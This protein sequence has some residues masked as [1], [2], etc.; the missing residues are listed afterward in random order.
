MR[1]YFTIAIFLVLINGFA[2]IP[3]NGLV[4]YWPFSGNAN[5]ISGKGNN[6]IV[7]G[8]ILTTDRFGNANS[9]YH[10][11]GSNNYI[12][13][14]FNGIPAGSSPRTISFW[15]QS[16]NYPI[17]NSYNAHQGVSYGK[18]ATNSDNEVYFWRNSSK[19]NYLR[20]SGF[21]NDL[22]KIVSYD[23]IHWYN[24]VATFDGSSAKVYFND[25]LLGSGSFAS[26]N[27]VLD[28]VLFG[29]YPSHLNYHNGKIDDV[30]IYNRVLTQAGVDS[31]FNSNLS[32]QTIC[33]NDTIISIAKLPLSNTSVRVVGY[34]SDVY[35]FGY[36]T[37]SSPTFKYSTISNSWSTLA[38]MPT[39]RG[40][41]GVAEVNGIIY[42]I[43]G[44]TGSASNKNE[45]YNIS[46]NTWST[47]A[48]L[49]TAITGCYAITLNNKIYVIGGTLGTTVTYFYEYN[50]TTNTYSTLANPSQ[51]RMHAGL[52]TYNNKIYLVGGHYFNGTY[53][54]SNK[55]DEY[56]VSLNSW[57]SKS[58]IPINVQR[59]GVNIYDNKLYLF[60]GTT[61]AAVI[62]PLNSLY[63]YDFSYDSWTNMANMPFTRACMEAKT[64]NS[65]VYLFS[66]NNI[67][68]LSD[69]CYKYYCKDYV[70]QKI[71]YDTVKV[72]VY[73]TV[74]VNVYDTITTH[75][76]VTDTLIINA[77]LTGISP[78]NNINT[79]RVYPNPAKSHVYI[80]CGKYVTMSGYT[81]KINNSIAQ[82]VFTQLINQQQY[83]VNLSSWSG[84][85]TYFIYIIDNLGNTIE[86]RKIILQ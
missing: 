29:T 4:G 34:N 55:L 68:S 5:D 69:S 49:P 2:Q 1:N 74:R 41:I 57:T 30:L 12:A 65:T 71:I 59:M 24:I 67:G 62:T 7:H 46:T 66:G 23:T 78:P 37:T 14:G 26:W 22:D 83:Y 76:A 32:N 38:N 31:I 44:F 80:D 50:P 11:N 33:T 39:A 56:N 84:N 70:C 3:L 77:K 19:V 53:N 28:S 51:N 75:I 43:G 20:Y 73:D 45:A 54:S 10:F 9:A 18:P 52:V 15:I 48:N 47:M 82:T 63:V 16:D 6:G 36:L 8:A 42:C 58:N 21:N 61:N 25:T 40:E 27:T 35:A 13:C 85:G 86:V 64:V 17:N 72:N 60:G 81:I 79:I